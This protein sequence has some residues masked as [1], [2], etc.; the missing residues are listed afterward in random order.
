MFN[1]RLRFFKQSNLLVTSVVLGLILSIYSCNFSSS[2]I[3]KESSIEVV[4]DSISF[5]GKLYLERLDP[6]T[7]ILMDSIIGGDSKDLIFNIKPEQ[8][9]EIYVLRFSSDQAITII[10]DSISN[11]KVRISNFP[12]NSNYSIIGSNSSNIIKKNN[13]I[14]NKHIVFFESTYSEY[15]RRKRDDSFDYYRKQ[16]DSILRQNQI[17]LYNQLKGSIEHN[18]KSLASL[19]AIYSKFGSENIFN[20]NYDLPT[21][22]LL[23]DSLISEFPNNTHAIFFYNSVQKKIVDI[24]LKEKRERLLDE[25]NEYPDISL[26]SLDNKYYNIKNTRADVIVIYLWKSKYK[27]FWDDNVVLRKLYDKFDRNK[28]EIIGISFEKDKLSWSNYC[29]MEKMNWINLI[30]GPENINL[31]NPNDVYPRIFVL[32]S[33]FNILA[34]DATIEELELILNK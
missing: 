13:S 1:I 23:A 3:V 2:S 12:Y 9:P 5:N 8:F 33:S 25:G 22:Q 30:S 31:I 14:L 6:N 7:T 10:I 26:F 29:R 17:E 11:V 24:E 28:L 21:F 16:T 32:D 34:K 4:F 18:P 20:I 27:A 19:L 15:R